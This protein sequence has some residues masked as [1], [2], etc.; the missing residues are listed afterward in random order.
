VE[1]TFGTAWS[2]EQAPGGD[3]NPTSIEKAFDQAL[4][5]A[6][7][8]RPAADIP[9][10]MREAGEA[11][12]AGGLDEAA[13]RQ[14]QVL[15]ELDR[16]LETMQPVSPANSQNTASTPEIAGIRDAGADEEGRQSGA[17]GAGEARD[18]LAGSGRGEPGGAVIRRRRTLA[19]SV[20]GHLPDRYREEM[21][22]GYRERYLPEYEN[23][24]ERYYE[25]LAR[26]KL[27][28]TARPVQ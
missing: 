12:E 7:N 22:Q 5:E 15:E 16:L 11:I 6:G 17:P 2:Q 25:A 23:L 19:T 20:W 27:E 24:V 18:S 8:V 14:K 9:S 10:I 3:S 13:S 1:G 26:Q 4:E 28:A 21:Q